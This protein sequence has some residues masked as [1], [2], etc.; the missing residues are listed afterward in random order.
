MG[1]KFSPPQALKFSRH[2]LAGKWIT[3]FSPPQ[4]LKFLTL[5]TYTTYRE[6]DH[7]FASHPK[8]MISAW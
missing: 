5:D 1:K 7:F 4:A 3:N 8:K 6:R 2:E